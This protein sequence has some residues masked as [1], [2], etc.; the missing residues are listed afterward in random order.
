MNQVFS[1][2][3]LVGLIF[4]SLGAVMAYLITYSEW[5]HHYPDKKRPRKMALET[6][7]F[8]FIFFM[9]ITLLVGWFF[10]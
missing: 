2:M 7:I 10:Q 8:T 9:A 6:A 4:G 3:I 5:I 1:L